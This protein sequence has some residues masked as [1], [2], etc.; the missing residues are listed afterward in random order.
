MKGFFTVFKFELS[1]FMKNKGFILTT[2]IISLIIALGLSI[3]SILEVF[4]NESGSVAEEVKS[5]QKTYGYVNMDNAVENIEDLKEHFTLGELMEV[6]SLI[7]LEDGVNSEEFE[8]GFLLYSPLEYE[9][10]VKN[11]E[12]IDRSIG[13][14]E[15]ALATS[16]R[17]RE[18]RAMDI[19]YEDIEYI[20]NPDIKSSTKVLGKDSVQ[21]Y[22]YTYLLIFGLY[23]MIIFYGQMIATS[24]ASEKSNRAMEVLITSTNSSNLIFGKVMAGALAGFIQFGT[25]IMVAIIS[26]N[27]NASAWDNSLDFVFKIP[28]DV[29]LIFATFGILGYLFF[30]FIFGALGALVSRTEDVSTSSMPIT[31]MF[32]GVFMVSIIGMQNTEGIVLKVA[33]FIPFSSFMAMFVRVSMGTVSNISIIISLAILLASTVLMGLIGSRIYRAGTLMY[34]NRVKLKDAIKLLKSN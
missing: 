33:S 5:S 8:A 31:L 14:F 11:N 28:G 12:M 18:F 4:S 34:G 9:Y 32:I 20:I 24:V 26:Y 1:G 2:L 19:E 23:F 7:K 13:E 30:A 15:N 17:I 29:L 21:N 25:I 16:Y 27:L 3:P 6:D 10:I 22:I